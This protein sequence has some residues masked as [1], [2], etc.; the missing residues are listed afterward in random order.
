MGLIKV[1]FRGLPVATDLV[2][3]HSG[4]LMR[5]TCDV[6]GHTYE[7]TIS[8][9]THS[10]GLSTENRLRKLGHQVFARGPNSTSYIRRKSC[11]INNDVDY[12]C[13]LQGLYLNKQTVICV[14]RTRRSRVRKQSKYRHLWTPDCRLKHITFRSYYSSSLEWV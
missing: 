9:L 8:T 13:Y 12:E 3:P 1:G 7:A 6:Y 5:Q 2:N 10:T 4:L 14:H 11:F